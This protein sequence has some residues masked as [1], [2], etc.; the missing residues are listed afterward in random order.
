MSAVCK[1]WLFQLLGLSASKV[2]LK[3]DERD[4]SK[5]GR[6]CV[7][8]FMTPHNSGSFISFCSYGELKLHH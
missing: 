5:L 8:V 2:F 1:W 7:H 3:N 6:V 4:C